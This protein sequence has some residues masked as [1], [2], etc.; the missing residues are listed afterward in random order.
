VK[1]NYQIDVSQGYTVS[2]KLLMAIICSLF[3]N[4]IP[5]LTKYMTASYQ[6]V[7]PSG[8]VASAMCCEAKAVVFVSLWFPSTETSLFYL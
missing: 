4:I 5:F 6:I 7:S 3:V 2:D 8:F 1:T